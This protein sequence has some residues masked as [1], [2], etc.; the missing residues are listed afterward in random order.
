MRDIRRG[1]LGIAFGI[2]LVGMCAPA[3]WAQDPIHKLGRG[4]VNVL[5]CWI[6]FPKNL[7]LGLQEDNPVTGLR[8]GIFKGA[9][10]ALTRLAVGAYETAS[11]LIPYPQGYASPYEGMELPDYAWQ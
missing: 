9:G 4:A 2:A 3:A 11:F 8:L 5:T 1:V 7:H 10:L 6:E